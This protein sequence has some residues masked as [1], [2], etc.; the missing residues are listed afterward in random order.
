MYMC[1]HTQDPYIPLFIFLTLWIHF[2]FEA[3]VIHGSLVDRSLLDKAKIPSFLS[4]ILFLFHL[5][6]SFLCVLWIHTYTCLQ[7]ST[8]DYDSLFC[9]QYLLQLVQPL[10]MFSKFRWTDTM[11]MFFLLLLFDFYLL[12][13]RCAPSKN[14][15]RYAILE[16]LIVLLSKPVHIFF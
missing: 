12:W 4:L 3:D 15:R 2:Y 16:Y 13:P 9:T 7:W 6:H 10:H 5:F 14:C 1:T 11:Q 8:G